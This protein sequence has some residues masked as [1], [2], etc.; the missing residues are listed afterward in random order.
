MKFILDLKKLLLLTLI[1]SQTSIAGEYTIDTDQNIQYSGYVGYKHIFS[2][3]DVTTT[4]NR[5]GK[6]ELGLNIIYNNEN[7]QIFNQFRYGEDSGTY[8]VYNFMQYTFHLADDLNLSLRGGKLRHELGLYNT[9]R[10]NPKTRQGVIQPQAIYWDVFDEFLTSGVGVG[11]VLRY[12]DLELTYTIDDPTIID[13][14]KTT[15]AFYGPLL[16]DTVTEFG[17]HQNAS[18]TYTPNKIPLIFKTTWTYLNHG[19]VTGP[20]MPF[21]YPN[22]VNKP[23]VSQA[24]TTGIEYRI[25]NFIIA[26]EGIWF[27]SADRDWFP[28]GDLH[29][30]LSITGTYQITEHTDI[31]INYNEY[32]SQKADLFYAAA[33][34]MGYSTDLNLGFNYHRNNWMVQAEGHYIQGGRTVDTVDVTRGG[35]NLEAYKDWWMIGMN[36]V[37]FF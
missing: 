18:V 1:L 36:V 7:F 34:W 10:V 29:R 6:P 16:G 25:N 4:F 20:L 9:T 31:R 24:I 2:D 5:V 17:S 37:Y 15:R 32:R 14:E 12:K 33:P 35:N 22:L 19:S 3:N 30:G 27:K 26:G 8:L 13:K 28:I 11:A 21:V 23:I